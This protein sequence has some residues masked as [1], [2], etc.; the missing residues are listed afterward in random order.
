VSNLV[1]DSKKRPE[2][3]RE[4]KAREK[5]RVMQQEAIQSAVS[6]LQREDKVISSSKMVQNIVNEQTD[7]ELSL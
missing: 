6:D 2:K 4:V 7:I 3:L 5:L 1:T